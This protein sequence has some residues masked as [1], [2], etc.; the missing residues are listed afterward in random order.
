MTRAEIIPAAQVLLEQIPGGIPVEVDD[1]SAAAK[2]RIDAHLL[3]GHCLV[4]KP[5]LSG[6]L[7]S[8]AGARVSQ[9]VNLQV[10]VRINPQYLASPSVAYQLHDAITTKLC[11]SQSFAAKAATTDGDT[12]ALMPDDNGLFTHSLFFHVLVTNL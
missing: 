8:Q 6:K 12:F 10:H 2:Q 1:Y 9:K 5:L 4:L 11:G 7:V 3:V